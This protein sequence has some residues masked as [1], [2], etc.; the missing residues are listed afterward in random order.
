MRVLLVILKALGWTVLGLLALLLAALFVPV[1]VLP[2]YAE[3]RTTARLR[4]LGLTFTLYDSAAP[5][6]PDR[7]KK[8]PETAAPEKAA[9]PAEPT[10]KKKYDLGALRAMLRPAAGAA[11]W[12]LRRIRFSD[13]QIRL[14]AGGR[15]AAE[16]GINTG[17][18]WEA[19]AGGV[20]LMRQIWR[21]RFLE[22]NVLPD[23]LQEHGG[24]EVL[25]ARVTAVPAAFVAAGIL[26]LYRYLKY[27]RGQ[28][29]ARRAADPQTKETMDNERK[30][31]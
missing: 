9:E 27:R 7:K 18:I 24:E 23:F 22:L 31:A 29:K 26:F 11:G 20:T 14:V 6:K 12:L 30:S 28:A 1:S 17:R 19:I 15:D 4:V 5:P 16:V 25:S 13:I 2:R 8:K 3:G 21:P 10:P